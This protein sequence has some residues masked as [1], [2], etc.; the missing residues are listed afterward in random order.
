[1]EMRIP[2]HLFARGGKWYVKKVVRGERLRES[3]G[4]R[5]GGDKELKQAIAQQ[6]KIEARWE[7]QTLGG[8]PR[9]AP[10]F[11]EWWTIYQEVYSAKTAKPEFDAYLVRQ[12]L[13]RW[14]RIRL[15]SITK[16][17]CEGYLNGRLKAVSQG[18]VNRE[19]G[20]LQ[21]IFERAIED[22][23]LERNPFKAI[24]RVKD[25]I[26][27]RVLTLEEQGRLMAV[28]S[29]QFQRWLTVM[30]GTGLRFAEARAMLPDHLDRQ[31][32]LLHVQAHAAKN[33]KAR[34]VPLY[35]EVEQAIDA[36]WSAKGKLWP[37]ASLPER[38]TKGALDAGIPHVH[39][40]VLRHTFATRYLQAGGD[41][42]ILS[43]I[44][45]HT[46]VVLTQQ[47]YVHVLPSD[48]VRRSQGLDLG[49]APISAPPVDNPAVF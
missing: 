45:G 13:D 26:R 3:T 30:L 33:H 41:I 18:T 35:V 43:K 24:E 40:H 28:L 8:A 7:K 15:T 25:N 44:L 21:A 11:S 37:A 16:S 34:E 31:E 29:P 6:Q 9:D 49:L 23:L 48:L 27:T 4:I 19:R 39:P 36:Q 22:N 17:M 47:Q 2:P 42:F 32:R 1:M 10:T 20:L 14:K 5:V 46:T 12:A 38:L